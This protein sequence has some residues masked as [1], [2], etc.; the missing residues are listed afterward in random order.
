V[1]LGTQNIPGVDNPSRTTSTA[2]IAHPTQPTPEYISPSTES[3]TA[4]RSLADTPPDKIPELIM[5]PSEC[6]D[7]DDEINF[8]VQEH[9][10]FCSIVSSFKSIV[11][12][13][14]DTELSQK[15]TPHGNS[16][17]PVL[18]PP[19]QA[20]SPLDTNTRTNQ[21]EAACAGTSK[22]N[23]QYRSDS[24]YRSPTNYNTR[25]PTI[26]PTKNRPTRENERRL[27]QVQRTFAQDSQL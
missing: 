2:S 16:V 12:I 23:R 3:T 21:L 26:I 13:I 1:V 15:A 10:N 4:T 6:V 24:G 25:P 19:T 18:D 22:R 9:L 14:W 8:E 5:V 17:H 11:V 27:E 20:P 7:P